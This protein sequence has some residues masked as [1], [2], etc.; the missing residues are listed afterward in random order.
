MRISVIAGNLPRTSIS[1]RCLEKKPNVQERSQT[2]EDQRL[3]ISPPSTSVEVVQIPETDMSP[4][5]TMM[6]LQSGR[7]GTNINETNSQSIKRLPREGVSPEGSVESSGGT[8]V[9]VYC[10]DKFRSLIEGEIQTLVEVNEESIAKILVGPFASERIVDESI[11]VDVFGKLKEGDQEYL[12]STPVKSA[13]GFE[14]VADSSKFPTESPL[15]R[16]IRVAFVIT[17]EEE[18]MCEVA[19]SRKR[20]KKSN[21]G[22]GSRRAMSTGGLATEIGLSEK[23]EMIGQGPSTNR[24][25]VPIFAETPLGVELPPREELAGNAN[26]YHRS[27]YYPSQSAKTLLK[28]FFEL[29]PPTVLDPGHTTPSLSADQMIHFACAVSLEVAFASNGLLEG[30]LVRSR[31]LGALGSRG[32]PGRSPYPSAVGSFLGDSV[33]SQSHYSLQT[34][35]GMTAASGSGAVTDLPVCRCTELLP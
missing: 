22:D 27:K 34:V 7:P 29:N 25:N 28:D 18:L 17:G 31:G 12:S 35:T 1:F 14:S 4:V 9:N 13:S 8:D 11:P 5:K 20:K 3:V 21:D 10:G 15:K 23:G 6:V 32:G 19:W 30:L 24:A 33:A 16:S 2:G 26:V